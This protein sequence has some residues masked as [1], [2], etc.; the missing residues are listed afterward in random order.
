M[1]TQQKVLFK[2]E[3]FDNLKTESNKPKYQGK[4]SPCILGERLSPPN[5]IDSRP[6]IIFPRSSE[7]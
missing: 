7:R 5:V 1:K 6:A 3:V 4:S 2:K